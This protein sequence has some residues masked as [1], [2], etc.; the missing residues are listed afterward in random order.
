M[1]TQ[2]EEHLVSLQITFAQIWELRHKRSQ[3]GLTGSIIN[4]PVDTNVT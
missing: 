4:V 3:V 1:L 2:L